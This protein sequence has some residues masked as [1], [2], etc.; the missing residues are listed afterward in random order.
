M[1]S[2]ADTLRVPSLSDVPYSLSGKMYLIPFAGTHTLADG[3]TQ[4]GAFILARGLCYKITDL[5]FESGFII[6]SQFFLKVSRRADS[7]PFEYTTKTSAD[8]PNRDDG[9]CLVESIAEVFKGNVNGVP[10]EWCVMFE[11][12]ECE[13]LQRLR[14][15]S[16][17]NTHDG[18]IL[19]HK[20]RLPGACPLW[21]P[22][23][24][25]CFIYV[26]GWTP[27]KVDVHAHV[28]GK[29]VTS[30][31]LSSPPASGGFFPG[32][33]HP[34]PVELMANDLSAGLGGRIEEARNL[35]R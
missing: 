24:A 27:T 28:T 8:G 10:E 17:A 2:N 12:L 15:L 29:D 26:T 16:A 34:D 13:R 35:P 33:A 19:Q 1:H 22:V 25:K 30:A 11:I 5:C 21:K 32:E 4:D 18:C 31:F 20:R 23:C 9:M 3:S 7:E 6:V 14:D